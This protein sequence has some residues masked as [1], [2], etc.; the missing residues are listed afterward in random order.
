MSKQNHP[1]P[2]IANRLIGY[3]I[4][5]FWATATSALMYVIGPEFEHAPGHEAVLPALT[6]GIVLLATALYHFSFTTVVGAKIRMR[7]TAAGLWWSRGEDLEKQLVLAQANHVQVQQFLATLPQVTEVLKH[8]LTQTTSA[9]ESA[10]IAILEQLSNIEAEARALSQSLDNSKTRAASLYDNV[11]II[12]EESQQHLQDMHTYQQQ[13]QEQ[14]AHDSQAIESVCE[15]IEE[16]KPLTGL[17]RDVTKQTNLLALNAA[18]EA[19]RAGEAGRG[20]AVV[21]DEVRNLSCKIEFAA[22][23]IEQ[24][25]QDVSKTVQDK[26]LSI[27]SQNRVEEERVWLA[28]LSSAMSYMSANFQTA[29]SELDGLSHNTYDRV[30]MILSAVVQLLGNVQFQDIT[31]QQIGAVHRLLDLSCRYIQEVGQQLNDC[32]PELK[33]LELQ[34]IIEA[35]RLLQQENS[36]KQQDLFTRPVTAATN[37][38]EFF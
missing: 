32:N 33:A 36:T 3:S 34:L 7:A 18:I 35:L 22:I 11:K 30:N 16:L 24:S 2:K 4:S 15:R 21:S 1:N 27:T 29:V 8:H 23:Q 14:L 5:V 37:S 17:I 25:I 10:A 26:L 20:F 6:G 9:T 19:A 31:S 12:V 28:T 13:R 38:I